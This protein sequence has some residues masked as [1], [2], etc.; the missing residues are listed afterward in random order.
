MR[1]SISHPKNDFE[2]I[3]SHNPTKLPCLSPKK[4]C[5][6]E[7]TL[8]T[9]SSSHEELNC[10]GTFCRRRCNPY[11]GMTQKKGKA[12]RAPEARRSKV[13]QQKGG[14]DESDEANSDESHSDDR[15]SKVVVDLS[16]KHQE[17]SKKQALEKQDIYFWFRG[18]FDGSCLQAAHHCSYYVPQPIYWY[19]KSLRVVNPST[20]A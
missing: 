17:T 8:M 4:S 14:S 11:R 2:G 16:Q 19:V 15:P 13:S 20:Q 6:R 5:T 18:N 10:Q 12:V 9:G 7:I 1:N 3:G